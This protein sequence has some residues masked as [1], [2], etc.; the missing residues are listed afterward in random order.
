MIRVIILKCLIKDTFCNFEYQTSIQMAIKIE[1]KQNDIHLL[2]DFYHQKLKILK[3][4][5]IAKEKEVRSINSMIVQLKSVDKQQVI[6]TNLKAENPINQK[7]SNPAYSPDW[8]WA[9]KIV[10]A[11]N[12]KGH[13]LN[14][15][16]IIEVLTE[17]E[18]SILFE[19]K[20]TLA[21]VSSALSLNSGKGKAFTRSQDPAKRLIYDIRN[22]N[23]M[24]NDNQAIEVK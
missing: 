21:S 19:H 6:K 8:P 23:N 17:F 11:L 9:K 24:D 13:A 16:E 14:T 2:I 3:E 18:P 10:F 20:K 5:I 22:K 15:K 7:K 12:Y 4:E 1:V